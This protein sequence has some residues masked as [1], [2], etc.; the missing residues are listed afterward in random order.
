VVEACEAVDGIR[1]LTA[2]TVEAEVAA[3]LLLM[4]EG[5][6]V[7]RDL[8]VLTDAVEGVGDFGRAAFRIEGAKEGVGDFG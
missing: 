5:V 7:D 1:F 4:V 2:L 6:D 8:A 3:G